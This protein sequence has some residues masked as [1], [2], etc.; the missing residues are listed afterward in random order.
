LT[1]IDRCGFFGRGGIL[2]PHLV[3]FGETPLRI[4]EI[5]HGLVAAN[6]FLATGTSRTVYLAARFVGQAG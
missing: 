1:L 3:R 5:A 2:R 6:L 4:D